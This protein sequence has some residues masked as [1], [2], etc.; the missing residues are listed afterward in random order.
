MKRRE[1]VIWQS[2][3]DH[4]TL[5]RLSRDRTTIFF[6][7]GWPVVKSRF[8]VERWSHD[9]LMTVSYLFSNFFEVFSILAE[10]SRKFFP[11]LAKTSRPSGIDLVAVQ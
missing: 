2:G 8:T 9:R 4:E 10:M 11:I 5:R 6:Y 1:T 7:F 3:D